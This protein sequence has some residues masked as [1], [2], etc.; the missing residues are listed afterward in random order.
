MVTPGTGD[1][2]PDADP[3]RDFLGTPK[4]ELVNGSR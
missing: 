2:V 4:L 3:L 1:A